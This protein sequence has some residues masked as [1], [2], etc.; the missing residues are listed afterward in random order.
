MFLDIKS[1]VALSSRHANTI[2]RW[3]R[4][5]KFKWSKPGGTRNSSWSIDRESFIACLRNE[6]DQPSEARDLAKRYSL[7]LAA[8]PR[9]L[10]G[11]TYDVFPIFHG[12]TL[13]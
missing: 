11:C 6:H 2:K 12:R 13:I 4:S 10:P 5:G 1:A 3:G 7:L 8:L 9:I